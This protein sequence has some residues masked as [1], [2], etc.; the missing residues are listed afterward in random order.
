VGRRFISIRSGLVNGM[1]GILHMWESRQPHWPHTPLLADDRGIRDDDPHGSPNSIDQDVPAT[2]PVAHARVH[3][4]QLAGVTVRFRGTFAYVDGQL[5]DGDTGVD[6]APLRRVSRPLGLGD[7]PGQQGGYED[8]VL[9]TGAF[10]GLPEDAL[11]CAAGLYLGDP[12]S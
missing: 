10:A 2:A 5:P 3:W 1:A 7:V 9:P 4:P 12:D 11:D 8:A 6:A